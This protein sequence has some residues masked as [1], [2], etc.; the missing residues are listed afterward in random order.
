MATTTIPPFDGGNPYDED[1]RYA[2]NVTTI[3]IRTSQPRQIGDYTLFYPLS[4]TKASEVWAG[5]HPQHGDIAIKFITAATAAQSPTTAKRL[6]SEIGMIRKL[7]HPNIVTIHDSDLWQGYRWLAMPLA[8]RG[9][10]EDV[11]KQQPEGHRKVY[12]SWAALVA[13]HIARAL[14]YAHA[15][16]IIHRDVKPQNILVEHVT[17]ADV[18]LSDFG[19]AYQSGNE[20]LTNHGEALGTPYYMSPEQCKGE[21]LDVRTDVYSL[22]VV[23]YELL[24]QRLPF[25]GNMPLAVAHQHVN[26]PPPPLPP[27]V[28]PL[29]AKV[30]MTALA[31]DRDWRYQSAL[32]FAEALMPFV[33]VR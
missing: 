15:H 11:I 13:Q 1:E 8:R 31:K 19:I 10:L 27:S 14:E 7:C 6:N 5:V 33:E 16:E 24:A 2:A 3:P 25:E 18:Q 26:K 20:R 23:L 9:T 21:E 29:L 32:D 17:N 28:N 22:G 30:V 4:Q 12:Q